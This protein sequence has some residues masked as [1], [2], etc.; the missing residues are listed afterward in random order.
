MEQEGYV[1]TQH[2]QSSEDQWSHA[3]RACPQCL[4]SLE[5]YAYICFG[6]VSQNSGLDITGE[7]FTVF[8]FLKYRNNLSLRIQEPFPSDSSV[9]L[10][11]F[12]LPKNDEKHR[13]CAEPHWPQVVHSALVIVWLQERVTAFLYQSIGYW[14]KRRGTWVLLNT[15]ISLCWMTGWR[16]SSPHTHQCRH[17]LFISLVFSLKYVLCGKKR[18]N[19]SWNSLFVIPHLW[20]RC[21]WIARKNMCVWTVR[22]LIKRY[23]WQIP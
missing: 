4:S 22:N 17:S 5:S 15:A 14:L 2:T 6:S 3:Q 12:W 7:T 1:T 9:I 10:Y 11:L 16:Q 8:S 18:K 19:Y 23:L 13:D 20:S 21:L